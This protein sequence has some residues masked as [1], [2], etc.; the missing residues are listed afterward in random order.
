MTTLYC[1]GE[2]DAEVVWQVGYELLSLFND[3][4]I[5]F[6]KDY[7]KAAIYKLLHRERE[8]AYS[9]PKGLTAFLGRPSCSSEQLEEELTHAKRSSIK[10]RL[11]HLAAANKDVYFILKYLDMEAGWG[12]YYKLLEVIENFA[13]E[14]LENPSHP[15][16]N[17][18]VIA[19]AD[20]VHGQQ[21][22]RIR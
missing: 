3:A 5:L 6:S 17:I 2:S 15:R 14:A 13:K 10:F 20:W 12:T 4:S 8:V 22:A 18:P 1:E 9:A 16:E 7:R 21:A 11:I 19:G